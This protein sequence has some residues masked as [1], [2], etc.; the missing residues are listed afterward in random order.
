MYILVV[1]LFAFKSLSKKKEEMRF[2]HAS[3]TFKVGGSSNASKM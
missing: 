1:Y 2:F 3:H